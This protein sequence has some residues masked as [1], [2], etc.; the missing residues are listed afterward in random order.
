MSVRCREA[1]VVFVAGTGAVPSRPGDARRERARRYRLLLKAIH[2]HLAPKTYVEIGVADGASFALALPET[3][4]V[5]IDPVLKR[6]QPLNRSAKLFALTSDQ[7]FAEHDLASVLDGKPVDLA[8]I[9]GMHHFEFALRD[10][11]HLESFCARDSVILLHDCYP[12]NAEMASRTPGTGWWAGDVWKLIVCLKEYRPDLRV[13]VVDVSPTGLGVVTSLDPASTVLEEHYA[14]ICDRFIDLDYSV[15]ENEKERKL[16]R[17]ANEWDLV[18]ELLPA[19][20]R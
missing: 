8:F 6:Q 2:A 18:Q 16:N 15:L 17:I 3:L 19:T 7:F 10:F 20:A 12:G 4:A 13:S 14:E 11:M 1:M 5:G 9:D